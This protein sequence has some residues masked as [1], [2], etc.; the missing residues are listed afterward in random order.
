MPS[1]DS[2]AVQAQNADSH[3]VDPLITLSVRY[4]AKSK[5]FK[6]SFPPDTALGAT[7]STVLDF[8]G[9]KEGDIGGGTKVYYFVHQE[10]KVSDLSVTLKSLAGRARA[11]EL[12]LVEQL[13]QG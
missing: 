9:L 5:P 6:G 1:N 12:K 2:Q 3:P 13:T 4:V 10:E 11:L 8:F 7:K